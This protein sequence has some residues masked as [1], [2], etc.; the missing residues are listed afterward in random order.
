MRILYID[1]SFHKKTLSTN[2]FVEILRKFGEVDIAWDDGWDVAWD[3][4]SA[5]SEYVAKTAGY[6]AVVV[7]QLPHVISSLAKSKALNLIYVPM[8]DAAYDLPKKFW[9]GLRAVKVLCFSAAMYQIARRHEL[10]SLY[11]RYF[12][13]FEGDVALTDSASRP[14]IFLW[15]RRPFPSWETLASSIPANTFG[16][17]HIHAALD[18]GF[19][20]V[21]FPQKIELNLFSF[22]SSDWFKDKRELYEKMNGFEY[23]FAPRDREGIGFSFIDAMSRGMAVIG[24]D[25][26][27]LNEYVVHGENGYLLSAE[28]VRRFGLPESSLAV[29]EKSLHYMKKGA[30]IFARRQEYLIDFIRKDTQKLRVRLPP[31]LKFELD[32]RKSVNVTSARKK[33]TGIDRPTVSVVTVVRNAAPSLSRTFQSVF[34][35]DFGDFEYIV[36][37][38]ASSDRTIDTIKRYQDCVDTWISESD[39]GPYDAMLK[40]AKLARGRYVIFMNAG[41]EFVESHSL[42]DAFEH[43]P[44]GVDIIYGHHFY[45]NNKGRPEVTLARSLDEAYARLVQ[46]D[47]GHKWLSGIPC[48]Q[49]TFVRTELLV[50]LGFES[51][52]KIAADH[53]LLFTAMKGGA[54]AYHCNTFVANYFSGGLSA[55]RNSEC[56]DDWLNIALQH[57]E[58]PDRVIRFYSTVK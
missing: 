57:T 44:D 35:Q 43:V 37:D 32:R 56:I 54:R 29:R 40:G 30:A 58:N 21:K 27:T 2:F 25:L 9:R 26:P 46:G 19:D 52:F 47:L 45:I 39:T 55:Q 51:R 38:G 13:A 42:H 23:Y 15:Q 6:D 16:K 41:D 14:G 5:A 22:S 49:S 8:F 1:H 7:F 50:D 20:E 33:W 18:P 3:D 34:A 17:V 36:V 10:E 24:L 12:P 11:L 48:H 53:N 31:R 4:G 28:E